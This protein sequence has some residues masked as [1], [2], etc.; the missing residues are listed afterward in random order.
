MEK[1]HFVV[2]LNNRDILGKS[3]SFEVHDDFFKDMGGYINK[4]HIKAEAVCKKATDN[5]Y[6]FLIHSFGVVFMPCDR[7]LDD[8]E[9]RIDIQ[10]GLEVKIGNEDEDKGDTLIVCKEH[11]VFDL[12][13]LVYQFVALSLPI[14]RVHQPGR[15]NQAMIEILNQHQVARSDD[16]A[17]YLPDNSTSV[18]DEDTIKTDHRWDKLKLLLNK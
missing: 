8:I 18:E 7:C 1:Q 2:E 5:N 9:L 12:A 6:S 15:C 11:P 14:S 4:G 16:E 10:N 17:D 3:F 13:Y